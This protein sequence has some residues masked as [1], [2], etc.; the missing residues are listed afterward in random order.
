MQV[1]I[2]ELRLRLRVPFTIATGTSLERTTYVLSIEDSLGRVGRG[3]AAPIRYLGEDP[4]SVKRDLEHIKGFLEEEWPA[5][6]AALEA[7]RPLDEGPGSPLESLE[8]ALQERFPSARAARTATSVALHDLLGQRRSLSLRRLLGMPE[9]GPLQTAITI[10]IDTPA[11]MQARVREV[12]AEGHRVIKVKAGRR[13]EE[14]DDA[15]VLATLRAVHD[16]PILVDANGGWT[17]EQ[18]ITLIRTMAPSRPV[19][20]EQPIPRGRPEDLR[21]IREA[22]DTPLYADEDSL[23]PADLPGLLGCVDGINIK[24][25]KSGGLGAALRMLRHARSVGWGVMLGCM[26]ESSL[27]ITAAASLASAVDHLDLD[28]PLLLANDPYSGVVFEG[29]HLVLPDSPGVGARPRA[30]IPP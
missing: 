27:G 2:H 20:I 14:G 25:M 3:E 11:R 26:V 9:P 22:V 29:P 15:E 24:L 12:R 16:G 21:A 6:T 18:A 28:A 1:A 30:P 4:A 19:F 13:P 17:V 8:D 7:A 10:P 5:I 23:D